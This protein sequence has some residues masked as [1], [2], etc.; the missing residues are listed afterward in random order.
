MAG[1][2]SKFKLDRSFGKAKLDTTVSEWMAPRPCDRCRK[3]RIRCDRDLNECSN[4]KNSGLKCTYL[5]V[6]KKRGPKAKIDADMAKYTCLLHNKQNSNNNDIKNQDET[7]SSK[8][9]SN[10]G[11]SEG[12][13]ETRSNNSSLQLRNNQFPITPL[14]SYSPQFS[15]TIPYELSPIIEYSHKVYHNFQVSKNHCHPDMFYRSNSY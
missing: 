2:F 11:F 4:C 10:T 15:T 1:S 12:H 3:R 7:L 8:D 9:H 6:P 13:Y 5:D 14:S